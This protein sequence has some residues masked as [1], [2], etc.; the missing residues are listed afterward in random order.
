MKWLALIIAILQIH[1]LIKITLRIP[2]MSMTRR[3]MNEIILTRP[4]FKPT[5]AG[6]SGVTMNVR[7]R[8]LQPPD[9]MREV[10]WIW[11]QNMGMLTYWIVSGGK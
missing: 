8:V 4:W 2:T 6:V 9:M 5:H 11:W 3:T 1:H 7:N 10:L